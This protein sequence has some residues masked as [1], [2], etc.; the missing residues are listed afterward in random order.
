MSKVYQMVIVIQVSHKATRGG[1]LFT[2]LRSHEIYGA[3][4]FFKSLPSQMAINLVFIK[5]RFQPLG[6]EFAQM[7]PKFRQLISQLAEEARHASRAGEPSP[8]WWGRGDQAKAQA[9]RLVH[10]DQLEKRRGWRYQRQWQSA[11][12]NTNVVEEFGDK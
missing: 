7:F 8:T 5:F 11:E 4:I 1:F 2:G 6:I 9:K 12:I 3:L 10:Q